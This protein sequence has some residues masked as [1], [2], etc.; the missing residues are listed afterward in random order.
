MVMR[1]Y[2]SAALTAFALSLLFCWILIPLLK[3]WRAGQNILSYV[4][5]HKEKG[6]TPTMGGLAFLL[7]TVLTA[8]I[9]LKEA[10]MKTVFTL[11]VSLSFAVVGLLDDLLKLYHKENL[12]LKS[13]Q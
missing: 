12:G 8:V 1:I 9:F 13:W 5:E 7:A 6:G 2:L 11:A 4:K 3:K 10:D